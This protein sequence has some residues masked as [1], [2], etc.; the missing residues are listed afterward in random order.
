MWK[1]LRP[2]L[3]F[4]CLFVTFGHV[5]LSFL[6]LGKCEELILFVFHSAIAFLGQMLI[7]NLWKFSAS[8]GPRQSIRSNN[9]ALL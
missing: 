5:K 8:K 7:V 2:V 3:H 9:G 1:R 6:A 4:V